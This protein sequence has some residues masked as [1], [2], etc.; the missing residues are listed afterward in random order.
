M[1]KSN[2]AKEYSNSFKDLTDLGDEKIAEGGDWLSNDKFRELLEMR[3]QTIRRSS[4][5]LGLHASPHHRPDS[6]RLSRRQTVVA[7]K[8]D[9]DLGDRR[10]KERLE[11]E[12]M[13]L[14]KQLET[15]TK[16]EMMDTKYA[17]LASEVMKL[18]NSVTQVSIHVIIST[19]VIL[20]FL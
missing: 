1:F 20:F 10:E 5:T 19:R 9:L 7:I 4:S 3:E 2:F 13:R 6:P 15:V 17:S 12:N 16:G 14:R 18:Q 8:P 11:A